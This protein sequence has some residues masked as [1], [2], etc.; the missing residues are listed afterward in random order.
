MPTLSEH[1]NMYDVAINQLTIRGYQVWYDR[2]EDE[3][4]AERDGWD[5]IA[6]SPVGLL[7]LVSIYHSL[8]PPVYE[9]YWWRRTLPKGSTQL[10]SSP[11]PYISRIKMGV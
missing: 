3:F 11:T 10:V 8:S 9:E 6:D 7:G 5:F 1:V 2:V 4:W